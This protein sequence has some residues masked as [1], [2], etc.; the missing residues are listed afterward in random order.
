LLTRQLVQ[1]Q[2]ADVA[3]CL[4][5]DDAMPAHRRQGDRAARWR[6]HQRLADDRIAA[7]RAATYRVA[8]GIDRGEVNAHRV[9]AAKMAAAQVA[10]EAAVLAA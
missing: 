8:A 7:V 2:L 10:Q 9:G 6:T 1:G 5:E 3:L 4:A